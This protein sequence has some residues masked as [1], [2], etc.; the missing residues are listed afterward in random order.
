[1][2]RH[3]KSH[4]VAGRGNIVDA[5]SIRE[6]SAQV[7]DRALPGHWEGDLLVGSSNSAIATMVERHSRFTVLCKVQDKRA[8]SVVQSLIT[9]M[10]MLPERLRKSLTLGQRPGICRTQTV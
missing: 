10:R 6:R 4:R 1:M 2:F 8:E 5:I 3:A 9:Q 7:E